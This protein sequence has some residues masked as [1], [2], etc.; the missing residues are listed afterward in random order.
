MPQRLTK[1]PHSLPEHAASGAE[2]AKETAKAAGLRYITDRTPGIRRVARGKKFSYVGPD[3][4]VVRDAE[5][6]TR[7][8]SL[9][10]PPAWT[11][12]WICPFEN[13]HIQV[14]ARDAR[15][16]KQYRYHTRWREV[17]DSTK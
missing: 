17:R 9:V 14:T 3:G 4:R 13:G 16:G 15:G 1:V 6:L 12:V 8:R 2:D 7:I 11:D 10:V 5:A